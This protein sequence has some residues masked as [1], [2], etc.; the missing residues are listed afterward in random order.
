MHH[1]ATHQQPLKTEQQRLSGMQA[2][3]L[4]DVAWSDRI[5]QRIAAH[6]GIELS[7]A[8]NTRFREQAD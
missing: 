4:L 6:S 7:S 3:L 1:K 8:L 5:E 2:A